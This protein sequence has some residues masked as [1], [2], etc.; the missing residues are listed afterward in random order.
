MRDAPRMAVSSV[1]AALPP[2]ADAIVK[3]DRDSLTALLG[4]AHAALKAQGMSLLMTF[5]LPPA[6]IFLRVHDP[7]SFGDDI[8]ARRHAV[9]ERTRTGKP[10]VGVEMGRDTL[11]IF[12]MTP[13]MRDGKSIGLAENG[14]AVRQGFRRPRQAALR[15]RSRRA[16]F[17]RQGLQATLLDLRRCRGR[18]ARR[19]EE[20]VRPARSLRRDATLGGIP[21]RFI[22]VRSRITPASRRRA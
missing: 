9:V 16:L 17:R 13:I 4:G 1:V 18:H 15:R 21:P 12:A 8:S 5:T 11:S 10:I 14:V 20:R 19:A 3:G 6:T 2:V 22:S 7:K